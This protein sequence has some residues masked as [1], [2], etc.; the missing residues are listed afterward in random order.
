M[1][2]TVVSFA[3]IK[4]IIGNIPQISLTLAPHASAGVTQIGNYSREKSGKVCA[5]CG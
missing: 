4:D 1:E 3:D 2:P 5:I